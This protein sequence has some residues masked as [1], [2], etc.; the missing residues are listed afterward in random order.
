MQEGLESTENGAGDSG[1]HQDDGFVDRGTFKTGLYLQNRE[2]TKKRDWMS[3]KRGLMKRDPFQSDEAKKSKGHYML[4]GPTTV[5]KAEACTIQ[6]MR[7]ESI[8]G[9]AGYHGGG[10]LGLTNK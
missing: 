4:Q 5:W 1:Q 7:R 3:K 9:K 8:A 6:A 10:D 2:G